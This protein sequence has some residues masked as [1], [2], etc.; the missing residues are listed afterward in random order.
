MDLEK[1]KAK[2]RATAIS[3]TWGEFER[4]TQLI[5]HDSDG[6]GLMG[7]LGM[8]PRGIVRIIRHAIS[9]FYP[10]WLLGVFV[11]VQSSNRT[12]KASLV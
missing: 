8:V 10:D 12:C 7:K 11:D 6:T 2:D 3:Y 1:A 9:D 5:G 4:T